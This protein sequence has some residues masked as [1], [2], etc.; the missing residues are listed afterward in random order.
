MWRKRFYTSIERSTKYGV[1]RIKGLSHPWILASLSGK[2][3]CHLW[4][5]SRLESPTGGASTSVQRFQFRCRLILPVD[6]DGH[7]LLEVAATD[8]GRVCN[9]GQRRIR[10]LDMRGVACRKLAESALAIG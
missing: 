4:Y 7:A 3:E 2:E 5:V 8:G 1:C 6:N 9:L 10:L